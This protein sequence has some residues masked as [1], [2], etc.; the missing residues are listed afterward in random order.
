MKPATLFMTRKYNY[1]KVKYGE[2]F[3]G[4]HTGNNIRWSEDTASKLREPLEARNT[5]EA[6]KKK[7]K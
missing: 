1:T 5:K 4:H 7:K 3:Y 2:A 6:K